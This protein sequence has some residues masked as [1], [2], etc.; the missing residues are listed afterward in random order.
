LVTLLRMVK[1]RLFHEETRRRDMGR[2]NPHA[3]VTKNIG[4]CKS[5][6]TKG[7]GKSRSQSQAKGKIICFYCNKGSHKEAL[8]GLEKKKKKTERRKI[9]RRM[10][11]IPQ[12]A[13]Q[14]RMW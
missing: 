6:D 14:M 7:H 2:G 1:D 12:L 5:R 4:R 10:I 3:L 9:R 13:L 11:R 8:Q